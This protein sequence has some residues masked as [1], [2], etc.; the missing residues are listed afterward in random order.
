MPSASWLSTTAQEPLT[1]E[2]ERFSRGPDTFRA[3]AFAGDHRVYGGGVFVDFVLGLC[4]N[5]RQQACIR[6]YEP[7]ATFPAKTGASKMKQVQHSLQ[8]AG[9]TGLI[10]GQVEPV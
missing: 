5:P 9:C 4:E 6:L 2:I 7:R 8:V 1:A 10:L 3:F